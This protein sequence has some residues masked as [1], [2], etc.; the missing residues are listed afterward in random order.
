MSRRRRHVGGGLD[1]DAAVFCERKERFSGFFCDEGQVDVFSDEG[2]L[3]GAAEYEQCL[4]EVD[5]SRVYVVK[6]VDEL[7]VAVIRILAGDF[8]KRLR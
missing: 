8:E 5:R 2:P 4:G 6:A 3:V 7:A 1:G